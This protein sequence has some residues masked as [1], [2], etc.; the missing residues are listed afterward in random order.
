[1]EWVAAVLSVKP[2]LTLEVWMVRHATWPTRIS[3]VG[4]VIVRSAVETW[5]QQGFRCRLLKVCTS[6]EDPQ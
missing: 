4:H 6:K 3:V 5:R 1:M 2:H